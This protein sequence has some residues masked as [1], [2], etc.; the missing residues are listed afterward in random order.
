MSRSAVQWPRRTGAIVLAIAGRSRMHSFP[1]RWLVSGQIY[2]SVSAVCASFN[3]E[4]TTTP[5]RITAVLR[6][7]SVAVG[8]LWSL[9]LAMKRACMNKGSAANL[10]PSGIPA[11]L[12]T[13]D[14]ALHRNALQKTG[15]MAKSSY[16]CRAGLSVRSPLATPLS[17]FLLVKAAIILQR[18]Y[19][20]LALRYRCCISACGPADF[21]WGGSS[22]QVCSFNKAI[23]L[24]LDQV[25]NR[26]S[27][28][29]KLLS[30]IC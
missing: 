3:P 13:G 29:A 7:A 9:I 23:E 30:T 28:L 15:S 14:A 25:A 6:H 24:E 11:T 5:L 16:C 21:N 26:G 12:G 2:G 17:S 27:S 4:D 18:A 8:P 20:Q 10:P 19:T 1:L 22:S